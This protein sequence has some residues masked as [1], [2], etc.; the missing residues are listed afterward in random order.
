MI[1]KITFKDCVSSRAT[2]QI[3]KYGF[4]GGRAGRTRPPIF[5]HGNFEPAAA[6]WCPAAIS[7]V[8]GAIPAS[9]RMV[10][11]GGRG[12]RGPAHHW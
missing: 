8:D 3:D 1:S 11:G 9:T 12:G 4:I 10:G 2:T 6:R 5:H 7:P